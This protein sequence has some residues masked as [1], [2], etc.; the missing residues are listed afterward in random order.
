MEKI[1]ISIIIPIYNPIK[2]YL[3]Q[4]LE[5][6]LIQNLEGIELVLIL[7]GSNQNT[8]K[9]CE[10]YQNKSKQ[11]KIYKQENKGEGG[12]RNTGIEKST[13]EW[14]AFLDP[15]DWFEPNSIEI[16]KKAIKNYKEK[17]IDIM[18]FDTY[19]NY[20]NKQVENKF[21]NRDGILSEKDKEEIQLQ[22]IEK[23]ITKYY[24][25]NCNVSV[26]WAKLYSKEFILKNKLKFK[27]KIKRMPDTIFN[28]KAFEKATN[29]VHCNEYIYHYRKNENSITHNYYNTMIN[30]INIFLE[31]VEKY[32]KKYKKDER[33]I[34]TYY[35]SILTKIINFIEITGIYKNVTNVEN[36][37]QNKEIIEKVEIF[38]SKY[39]K[40][41]KKIPE[42]NLGIY[43]KLMLNSILKSNWKRI[44]L[45]VKIKRIIKN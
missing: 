19:I 5:S 32:I 33:F 9:I 41:L 28:I 8:E 21:Y 30:D 15:D 39:N 20:K 13:G 16:M 23:G 38:K 31:E 1:E 35:I 44:N 43:Q 11:I 42:Q 25:N 24:P 14:V 12:A 22:N 6:L 45:Y 27:E 29:I 40:E 4:A 17:A 3:E 2:E 10:K 36:V 18:I 7:D 34:Q 26:V 37:A